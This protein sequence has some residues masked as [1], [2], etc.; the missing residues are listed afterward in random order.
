MSVAQQ[1]NRQQFRSFHRL[2]GPAVQPARQ[3]HG[4]SSLV[5]AAALAGLVGLSTPQAAVAEEV[6]AALHGFLDKHCFSCHDTESKKGDLDLQAAAFAPDQSKN[7]S[8]WVTVHDR[9]RDGEMPP[10][11]KPRPEAGE[12]QAFLDTLARPLI[13]ADLAREARDGRSTWRRLNR[14]EYENSLRD[15]LQAPWLQVKEILPEDGESH[16]FNKIGDALDISH[17]QMAQYLAAAEY[18]LRQVIATQATRPEL[19]KKRYYAREQGTFTSH[20]KFTEFNRSP[21]RATFPVLGSSAQP[22]VRNGKLPISDAKSRDQEGMGVVASSYEPIE[23]KFDRFTA[24]LAGLYK[25]RF[26]AESVWVGPG[27]MPA[28]DPHWWTPDLDL[29]TTG[30][31]AEPISVYGETRPRLLRWLSA[32]DAAPEATT[33]DM[34]VLL[35][36]G[37]TIRVDAARLFRSRPPAW[38]NPLAQKDGQ[39]GV[40]FRWMEVEGPVLEGWP[41]AGHKLLFGDLPLKPGSDAAAGLEAVSDHPEADA[42]RLLRAFM[43]HAYRAPLEDRDV[44]RYLGVVRKAIASGSSFSEAMIAGYAGVLCSPAF[45]CLEE[46]PGQLDDHALA[47]RLSYFLW[48]STPDDT[49]RQLAAKNEL[50]R[51]E[52]L[53]VQ[54]ERML[55]DARARRFVNA[56]LAYWIDLRKMDATSPDAGLYPAYYLDDLL[57]ESAQEETQEFFADLIKENLPARTIVSSDFVMINERLA[58][59][60]G[61]P[62]VDGVAIRKVKLPPD[63]VRGGLMTQASVLKVTANGTTTSPVLRGVWIMERILGKPPPP[64]PAS[65]PAIEPDTR[66]AST[67]REQLDKHRTLETCSACHAKI[68]PAGFALES[69]DV[70]GGQREKY[71]ALGEGSHEPGYGK[72]GQPFGFHLGPAVDASGKLP[73]GRAF[74]DVRELKKVLLTDERGL[75]R[76]LV[77]QLTVYATGAPVTFGDRP[78]IEVILDQAAAGHFALRSLIQGIVH[79]ELFQRK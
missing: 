70:F 37:E 75:A 29:V 16:R 53:T 4:W 76:N 7:M 26:C 20:M 40:A 9:V 72:N 19:I 57:V 21:E 48:N 67:I 46:K 61:I 10:K 39:P 17:V 22:E 6:P 68:D 14:Y 74:Q 63:S 32:F 52:V 12:L 31:R 2:P 64:P 13:A 58:K 18:A 69:F 43:Q 5:V 42:E 11:K 35:I 15:L 65:V 30:R 28:K 38:H 44:Q 23:L 8:L 73:D 33:H 55:D 66:G 1:G 27:L 51:P 77:S 50:H 56:F 59:H 3:L 71:R 62:G 60:Y 36:K 49:L 78:R 47:A 34:E 41:S 25:L 45:V 54:A 24:P 79:S